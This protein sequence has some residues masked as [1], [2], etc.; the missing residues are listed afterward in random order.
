MTRQQFKY[1]AYTVLLALALARL[2]AAQLPAPILPQQESPALQRSAKPA[3]TSGELSLR[4][5]KHFINQ[6]I[7]QERFDQGPVH[8]FMLGAEVVGTQTTSSR[9]TVELIPCQEAAK[10]S[11][12]LTGTTQNQTSSF[13]PEA[14]I[15]NCGEYQFQLSK[16]VQFDGQV[17]STWSPAA[18]IRANQRN[19]AAETPF[20]PLPLVGAIADQTAMNIANQ[21]L[22]IAQQITAQKITRQIAPEFNQDVDDELVRL[23][24]SLRD[25]ENWKGKQGLST[26]SVQAQ[27]T[28]DALVLRLGDE[29]SSQAS[30]QQWSPSTQS[31]DIS[32][33]IDQQFINS[34]LN[35]LPA[36]PSEITDTQ[37]EMLL[38]QK[39]LP[40]KDTSPAKLFTVVLDM[41]RPI[42]FFIEEN[43]LQSEFR[44]SI[45]PVLGKSA[46]PFLLRTSAVAELRPDSIQI[47]TIGAELTSEQ[48]EDNGLGFLSTDAIAENIK[49]QIPPLSFPREYLIPSKGDKPLPKLVVQGINVEQGHLQIRLNSLESSTANN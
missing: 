13:T 3:E 5:S 31:T 7:S 10:L 43:E 30:G 36:V 1:I 2:A 46:G 40:I 27:T 15:R 38:K 44:F 33:E 37:L 26:L 21:R 39:S 4:V 16:Q 35:S 29:V 49:Q 25:L 42:Q 22:P 34:L 9:T 24:R 20:T 28:A 45:R 11:V 48:N 19:V 6:I 47:T 18:F 8:D 12:L 23:N 32:I 41:T 14:V 17:I